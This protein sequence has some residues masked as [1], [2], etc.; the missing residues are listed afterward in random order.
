[1]SCGRLYSCM[2][3]TSSRSLCASAAITAVLALGSIPAVAQEAAPSLELPQSV[4]PPAASAPVVAPTSVAPVVI[5]PSPTTAAPTTVPATTPT[6]VLPDVTSAA[7]PAEARSEPAQRTTQRA[8][9]QTRSTAQPSAPE[10]VPAEPQPVSGTAPVAPLN[11]E[12]GDTLDNSPV[13]STDAAMGNAAPVEAAPP[14][15]DGDGAPVGAIAGL[16]AL[17]AVGAGGIAA[18][19]SRRRSQPH[20]DSITGARTEAEPTRSVPGYAVAPSVAA[21]AKPVATVGYASATASPPAPTAKPAY[22]PAAQAGDRFAMPEGAVPTG[23]ARQQLLRDMV[24]AA[25][26]KANPFRSP[27]YRRKRARVIL[28]HREYLQR[29]QKDQFDWRAYRPTTG[30]STPAKPSLVDA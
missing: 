13:P 15:E 7:A 26:D 5:S 25:P 17:L 11:P 10:A 9:T 14:V 18:M 20:S 23:E 6:I 16:L 8:A 2:T 19:R 21:P 1:L 30:T 12:I 4:T 3:H 24:A 29:Q 27:S 28:Q 22:K